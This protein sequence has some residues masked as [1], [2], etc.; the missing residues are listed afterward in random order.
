MVLS[1]YIYCIEENVFPF[2]LFDLAVIGDEKECF[3]KS[4]MREGRELLKK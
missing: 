1:V 2:F 4:M 3:Y